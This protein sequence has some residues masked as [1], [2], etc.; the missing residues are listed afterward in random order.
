MRNIVI[1]FLHHCWEDNP[2]LL[3]TISS[4]CERELCPRSL[5]PALAWSSRLQFRE[6]NIQNHHFDSCPTLGTLPPD[7]SCWS[8]TNFCRCHALPNSLDYV[9]KPP[10]KGGKDFYTPL[11]AAVN[12]SYALDHSA[13]PL[14]GLQDCNFVRETFR[15]ITSDYRP[16]LEHYLRMVVAGAGLISAGVMLAN[17]SSDAN[18]P[19]REEV[20]VKQ[21]LPISGTDSS[22]IHI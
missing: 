13:L 10:P 7:G 22:N 1:R 6:G 18:C 15:T 8:G 17:N 19:Q 16:P 2:R 12:V 21:S 3:Y 4:S 5:C 14:L 20:F 9:C 11:V